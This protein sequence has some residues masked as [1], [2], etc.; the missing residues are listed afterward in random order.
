MD[1][2]V[3]IGFIGCGPHA[4]QNIYPAFR[5]ATTEGSPQSKPIGDLVACCD[6]DEDLAKR[7]A[8]TFGFRR[9]YTDYRAMLEHE[10]LDCVFCVMHPRLQAEVGLN[11]LKAGLPVFVEKPATETLEQAY[12]IKEACNRPGLFLMPAF[13]KRFSSPYRHVSE[14]IRRPE[15]GPAVSFEGRYNYG[16]YAGTDRYDFLNAFSCH[17]LDL[18]RFF[19]GNV[20]S[21]YTLYR[22]CLPE[23][24]GSRATYNEVLSRRAGDTPQEEAWFLCVRFEGGA[25]GTIVTNCLER[26]QE[27][28]TITGQGKWVVADDW[29][30]VTSYSGSAEQ[31]WVWEPHDQL[32][33]DALD[34]RTLHG[35]TGEV[36]HFVESVRDQTVPSPNIDDTIAHLTLEIAAKR[37]ASLGREVKLAEVQPD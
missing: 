35:F 7:N 10:E 37:S 11:C 21:V 36:R 20:E 26:V 30:R 15:F 2:L 19:M 25:V 24:Q 9:S 18:T 12:R 22:G 27:R 32:P 13:M 28:I 5:L 33:S 23:D 14:I 1:R 29:R 6:L 8:R 17:I 4:T 16:R 3:R 34:S 31:P